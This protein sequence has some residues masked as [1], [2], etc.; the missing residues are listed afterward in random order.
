VVTVGQ[1]EENILEDG[2]VELAEEDTRCVRVSLGHVIHQLQAHGETGILHL[3][4]IVFRCPH[5]RVND[6]LELCRIEIQQCLEAIQVDGLEELE[7]LNAMFGIL[8]EILIDHF[9]GTAENTVHDGRDLILHQ[10]LQQ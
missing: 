3:A 5:A 9:Q 4:I 8:V 1:D 10:S 6:E 2:D 7:E